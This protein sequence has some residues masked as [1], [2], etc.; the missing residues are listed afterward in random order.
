MAHIQSRSCRARR[1]TGFTLVE[2]LIALLVMAF[3]MLAIA[4][5]QVTM[6]RNSDL[7]K[8]RS[9]AVRL[10]QLKIEELRSFD[11]LAA[12]S[13]TWTYTDNVVSNPVGTPE[14]ITAGSNTT[15]TRAWSV[16]RSDG[17]T[18][19]TGSDLEKWINVSVVWDDRVGQSQRVT[20]N[21][22]IARNDPVA[23][24]GLIGGQARERVRYPK[25]R[26]INIPYP[27]V[28]LD[29]GNTSAFI[30]PP[31][32]IAYVFDNETG[33]I[34][35]ACTAPAPIA[36]TTLTRSGSA[37]TVA[38]T[39]HG[40]SAGSRVV[41]AGSSDSAFNG[42]YVVTSVVAG[43]SFAFVKSAPLPTATAATGGTATLVLELVE[44]MDLA[45][46]G[47]TCTDFAVNAYLLSGYVRFKTSGAAPTAANVE[48]TTDAT[49]DL[50]STGPFVIDSTATT[51]GPSAYACYAQR[52]KVLS[53]NNLDSETITSIVRSGGVVTVAVSGSHGFTPGLRIAIENV[54]VGATNFNNSFTV[55]TVTSSTLTYAEDGADDSAS[56]GRVSLIQQITLPEDQPDPSGYNSVQSRFVAYSC[57]V[58]P[59]N[60]DGD[61][62]TANAWWGELRLVPAA[63]WTI[64]NTSSTYRVCRFSG[65]YISNGNV[66]NHEHPRYY[67]RVSGALDNQNFLVIKGNDDCPTDVDAAPLNADY[68]NT[69]T[70]THQGGPGAEL[71]FKCTNTSCSGANKVTIEPASATDVVPMF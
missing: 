71:S 60:D 13:G 37:I 1:Q 38:A 49:L 52:Q 69:N 68:V 27:A 26:N 44:G 4:G 48:N 40:F 54:P 65:D 56:S 36:I 30:P 14:V 25:S 70:A 10:A 59:I 35:K 64:G 34:L 32:N 46:S 16:L 51:R 29:G 57:V 42:T 67:R 6:S 11:G 31:G 17:V 20:L 58:T 66:S 45:A 23:L 8:Q 15:F 47:F 28:T 41:V 61:N 19:A 3:G 7:A 12:G 53:A 18:A 33:N 63:T 2:A 22:V 5:L 50:L 24:K 21:S 62:A 9:E 39:G 55:L 43:V